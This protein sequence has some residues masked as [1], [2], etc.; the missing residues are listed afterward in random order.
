VR[1]LTLSYF[2]HP[3]PNDVKIHLL[4]RDLVQRGHQ[5]TAL[6]SFPNYPHGRIYPGYR[7]K[8]WQWEDKDGVRVAR[9]PLYPDH[10]RSGA[11]R[12][13]SYFSFMGSAALLGP[14]LSGPADV[15]LVYQPP[16]T[17][18]LAGWWL[19]ALRRAP[20]VYEIQDMWPETLTSTGMINNRRALAM[21]DS[22]ARWLYRRAAHITVISPGFKRNLIEKGVPADKIS[23]IPNWADEDLY[24]PLPRDPELGAACGLEGRFNI[25][26]GGNIG[27]A[28][29]LQPVIDTAEA[30]RA[31][32]EIQFVLIGDGLQLAEL[33][34]AVDERQLTN[35]RFIERQPPERM[36]AFFAWAD[37]LLV[38]LKDDPLFAITIP[39]KTLAYLA[40][41]RPLL[42][43][44][45]GDG[46]AV[47]EGAGA[48]LVSPPGDPHTLVK[49]I[50]S[51]Y[52]MTPA[53][54]DALG[55]A[56]RRAYLQEYRRQIAV[57]RYEQIFHEIIQ[58]R[59]RIF[60]RGAD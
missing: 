33:Q 21:L 35:V 18:G 13:L 44:I 60:R 43:A 32:P 54:R 14:F 6:A 22:A 10:S 53:E 8:L 42:G 30:L 27:P 50:R 38:H 7:Q 1:L 48:G 24:R 2:Y 20:F 25:I 52:T 17:T 19:S 12:A 55:Q 9:I 16:L 37:A 56:G 28:Q 49:N 34:A 4:G 47:I 26:Y 59:R 46:A 3:E 57:E 5:V 23:V 41:G 15:M 51:L 29:A 36:P 31:T 58:Q 11:K 45:S 40:C 39:S